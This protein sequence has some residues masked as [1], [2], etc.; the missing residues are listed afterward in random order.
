[1]LKIAVSP[2]CKQP[3]LGGDDGG[4]SGA[5]VGSNRRFGDG[6]FETRSARQAVNPETG[7]DVVTTDGSGERLALA[8]RSFSWFPVVS[9]ESS[10]VSTMNATDCDALILSPVIASFLTTDD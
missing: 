8:R 10:V 5:R 2:G 4:G 1:M 7:S 6:P 3:S 9:R